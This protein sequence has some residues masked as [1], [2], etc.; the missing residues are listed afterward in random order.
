M[1]RSTFARIERLGRT[2]GDDWQR[3][4]GRPDAEWPEDAISARVAEDL[5]GKPIPNLAVMT[6]GDLERAIAAL[7]ARL[8]E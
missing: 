7:Q 6:E 8:T 5:L 3:Y 1:S 4:A 2:Q